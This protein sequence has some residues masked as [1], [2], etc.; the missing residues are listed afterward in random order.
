[1][2]TKFENILL[3]VVGW[4]VVALLVW[5]VV[6]L[7]IVG[8]LCCLLACCFAC[9]VLACVKA[10]T[11][12]V[13]PVAISAQALSAISQG[14]PRQ[15]QVTR[16]PGVCAMSYL[17]DIDK[18]LQDYYQN[19]Y[20]QEE[21]TPQGKQAKYLNWN[22]YF[23]KKF[24]TE[25]KKNSYMGRMWSLLESVRQHAPGPKKPK[26]LDVL[27]AGPTP[28]EETDGG[29]PVQMLLFLAK[30]PLDTSGYIRGATNSRQ[31]LENMSKFVLTGNKTDMYPIEV[32]P[33]LLGCTSQQAVP[34]WSMGVSVGNGVVMAAHLFVNGALELNIWD[35]CPEDQRRSLSIRLRKCLQ[36]KCM[37]KYAPHM[38][39]QVFESIST[40]A[41]AVRRARTSILGYMAGYN[42]VINMELSK[43]GQRKSRQELLTDLIRWHNSQETTKT[44]KITP[45]EIQAMKIVATW[46]AEGQAIRRLQAMWGASPASQS[47]VTVEMLAAIYLDPAKDSLVSAEADPLWHAIYTPSEAKIMVYLQRCEGVFQHKIDEQVAAGKKPSLVSRADNYRDPDKELGYKLACLWV[48]CEPE[49]KKNN[50]PKRVA[51]LTE[52]FMHG[53]LD[54]KLT[55]ACR[56]QDKDFKPRHIPWVNRPNSEDQVLDAETRSLKQLQTVQEKNLRGQFELFTLNLDMEAAAHTKQ[57][58][59]EKEWDSSF[60][61][62]ARRARERVH[63]LREKAVKD[64]MT[65]IYQVTSCKDAT[66]ACSWMGTK[67]KTVAGA[68]PARPREE[69]LRLIWM[70]MGE[71]GLTHSKQLDDFNDIARAG[72]E[73]LPLMT[74]VVL[75]PATTPKEGCGLRAPEV[76]LKK[77]VMDA[78][79]DIHDKFSEEVNKTAL[80]PVN[81]LLDEAECYSKVRDLSSNFWVIISNEK[82]TDDQGA[83]IAYSSYFAKSFAVKRVCVPEVLKTH[84]RRLFQDWGK[85]M[86]AASDSQVTEV[87][88][89]KHWHTGREFLKPILKSIFRDMGLGPST[90]V[91]VQHYTLFS[92]ELGHTCMELNGER[93]KFMPHLAYTGVTFQPAPGAVAARVEESLKASLLEMVKSGKYVIPGAPGKETE[94]Q[95]TSSTSSSRRPTLDATAFTLTWPRANGE[96]PLRETV[97]QEKKALFGANDVLL[98][99]FEAKVA[100]HNKMFNQSGLTY[101]EEK[102]TSAD[103]GLAQGGQ[104]TRTLLE[105]ITKTKEDVGGIVLTSRDKDCEF[106]FSEDGT[107]M[108]LFGLKDGTL[109]PA[110]DCGMLNGSFKSGNAAVALKKGGSQWVE[111]DMTNLQTQIVGCAF[112]GE[113]VEGKGSHVKK[114]EPTFTDEPATLQAFLDYLTKKLNKVRMKMVKHDLVC[115]TDGQ[116]TSSKKETVVLQIVSDLEQ[117][118]KKEFDLDN[119]S[120]LLDIAMLKDP[121]VPKKVS[122]YHTVDYYEKDNNIIS[123]YP[124][125]RPTG[126]FVFKQGQMYQLLGKP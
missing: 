71:V 65:S 17:E 96:L 114:M 51:E 119:I 91:H 56:D 36:I 47:A 45:S 84:P 37:W 33:D 18:Q 69:I 105:P 101:K 41:H 7:W 4:W 98:K 27:P 54:T 70:D 49:M 59:E 83:S 58:E 79:K 80:M 123:D 32:A 117:R 82:D 93:H 28:D 16:S 24:N 2:K 26:L 106:I 38:K 92:P 104:E 113:S 42:I 75:M 67:L 20:N 120:G 72:V 1:M 13:L 46:E 30:L 85:A 125:V 122:I 8:L 44:S 116:W 121:D 68:T 64:E 103:A 39:G 21:D 73:A 50:T 10:I 88:A 66:A 100:E 76:Q 63:D 43:R 12:V 81:F 108:Y 40:K 55:K 97:L 14:P 109:T 115:Q 6:L 74:A 5:S 124:V 9:S 34:D 25:D 52:M 57:K 87:V 78:N 77:W 48:F 102:R 19:Q 118:K 110:T 86:Q 3:H 90:R 11:V 22:D 95:V 89:R 53:S 23:V 111:F 107:A 61:D 126:H 62:E 15:T 94:A 99:E 29:Q 112:H 60:Q 35:R 31:A